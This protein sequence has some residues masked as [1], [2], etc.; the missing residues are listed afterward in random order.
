MRHPVGC[1][2]G[3][4]GEWCLGEGVVLGWGSQGG[5]GGNGFGIKGGV[6][7]RGRRGLS[8]ERGLLGPG[9]KGLGGLR[10]VPA[11]PHPKGWELLTGGKS[12]VVQHYPPFL[13]HEAEKAFCCEP[14]SCSC[15]A[16][17]TPAASVLPLGGAPGEGG[18]GSP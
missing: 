18:R 14:Q 8:W 1:R 2:V 4:G 6:K 5:C 17:C 11:P 16:R 3:G 13:L 9:D 10:G 12:T 15:T 7:R